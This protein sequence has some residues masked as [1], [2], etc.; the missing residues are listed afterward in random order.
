MMVMLLL[1]TRNNDDC[2]TMVNSDVCG[3]I[4]MIVV[5]V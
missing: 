5:V 2:D 1:M 4:V 3:M